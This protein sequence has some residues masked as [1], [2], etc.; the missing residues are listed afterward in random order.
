MPVN[1]DKN[2]YRD[3]LPYEVCA[4][5]LPPSPSLR[6]HPF[7]MHDATVPH[8]FIFLVRICTPPLLLLPPPPPPHCFPFP[9]A[10]LLPIPILNPLLPLYRPGFVFTLVSSTHFSQATRVKLKAD[11]DVEGSDYINA[12]F[13]CG[14]DRDVPYIATQGPIEST[15]GDFWRMVWEQQVSTIAM[16]TRFVEGKK[17]KV[18]QYFPKKLN[19]EQQFGNYI[20]TLMAEVSEPQ[21]IVRRL[22]LV[23]AGTGIKR[24]IRHAQYVAW[25][26]HGVP[27]E[28]TSILTY[29]RVV[30]QCHEDAHG[31]LLVHCSAGV[32]RA[33]SFIAVDQA[34]EAFNATGNVDIH[35]TV[36]TMRRCR[37][38]V[39]QRANQYVYL[40]RAILDAVTTE[41]PIPAEG[42]DFTQVDF[43]TRF[44]VPSQLPAFDLGSGG[45]NILHVGNISRCDS[46]WAN[47][48]DAMLCLT[49]DVLLV[50]DVTP[51]GF[52]RLSMMPVLRDKVSVEASAPNSETA[53]FTIEVEGTKPGKTSKI[54]CVAEDGG[55]KREWEAKLSDRSGFLPTESLRGPR[56][57]GFQTPTWQ[58][59]LVLFG[60]ADPN[61][62]EGQQELQREWDGIPK[63]L[64]ADATLIPDQNTFPGLTDATNV[65]TTFGGSGA[66]NTNP[67]FGAQ[68][69]GV[70]GSGAGWMDHEIQAPDLSSPEP[71]SPIINMAQFP[72]FPASPET[73]TA[74]QQNSR[75]PRT[76][77]FT[78]VSAG[79]MSP[80]PGFAGMTPRGM[81]PMGML[82]MMGTAPGGGLTTPAGMPLTRDMLGQPM[83]PGALQ[84]HRYQQQ[85]MEAA[86]SGMFPGFGTAAP[87][88]FQ[89]VMP[90]FT[91][92]A[93]NMA[94]AGAAYN[95]PFSPPDS[96]RLPDRIGS[97]A[98]LA[99]MEPVH[100]S[101]IS[102]GVVEDSS[103]D[104]MDLLGSPNDEAS[105]DAGLLLSP[106]MSA[107][108][109]PPG[110]GLADTRRFSTTD[111]SGNFDP[112]GHNMPKLPSLRGR[113][114]TIRG[115]AAVSENDTRRMSVQS[116]LA[117]PL[118]LAGP[119]DLSRSDA[120][121][122]YMD[123][124]AAPPPGMG[125][126]AGAVAGAALT[127]ADVPTIAP[128]PA[129]P[130]KMY[131][132]NMAMMAQMVSPA[133]FNSPVNSKSDMPDGV[134]RW[135]APEVYDFD[136]GTMVRTRPGT[137][138]DYAVEEGQLD[139]S[140]AK[141]VPDIHP[142][143]ILNSKEGGSLQ[144]RWKKAAR[145]ASIVAQ[146]TA[147]VN[148][149]VKHDAPFG[150]VGKAAK[151]MVGG[152]SVGGSGSSHLSQFKQDDRK[153]NE[154][155]TMSSFRPRTAM[156]E[157][158]EAAVPIVVPTRDPDECTYLG[159]CT[160]PDCR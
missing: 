105:T 87:K 72:G 123:E 23:E 59:A 16:L 159:S 42:L 71:G 73:S 94:K 77:E 137:P 62:D 28:T 83:T 17:E 112:L 158:P 12:N 6:F 119:L 24:V 139:V 34:L 25:P 53:S 152:P 7:P 142:S 36:C 52:Y 85:Q 141:G 38:Y 48:K 39:V 68:I 129:A 113:Q 92:R 98:S 104:V 140:F 46:N 40:H 32:G 155:P 84:A 14:M 130:P 99:P 65:V 80:T 70:G 89:P 2:R 144:D 90:L 76:L 93:P 160:C 101:G 134:Q 133:I 56:I 21:F 49:T 125:T 114:G 103:T 60:C 107:I 26:D 82:P 47:A 69:E 10:R 115:L 118:E 54:L 108:G 126:F 111:L 109:G 143:T 95:P 147:M 146:I 58:E 138:E 148:T 64:D 136:D 22:D 29:R 132:P 110:K 15:T 86:M 97:L 124:A 153:L 75:V 67:L 18:F 100:T 128:A 102:I 149:P 151:R 37:P 61:T 96:A 41:P 150:L 5:P 156:H 35:S 91:P 20:V 127:R 51:N 154:M 117:E 66:P 4:A 145:R 11:D 63:I 120:Y 116:E 81:P 8:D 55:A 44:F 31:I 121:P 3:V 79:M 33:G 27:E 19:E 78:P 106:S 9:S 122:G 88:E 50:C 131:N 157:A 45:R 1:K 135:A 43:A 30:R 57:V 13:V 74:A